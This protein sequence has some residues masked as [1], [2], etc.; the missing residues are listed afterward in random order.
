MIYKYNKLVRDKIPSEIKKQP[1]R[2][3]SYF[4]MNDTEY[5]RALDEKLTEEL[6]E[7]K[8]DHSI[9]ELADLMEVIAAT[10][11]FRNISREELNNA[12]QKKRGKK[13]WL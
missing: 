10:M 1:G 11:K 7:Y 5:D 9:E 2:N 12:M 3:C 8:A 6:N 13:G 4:I